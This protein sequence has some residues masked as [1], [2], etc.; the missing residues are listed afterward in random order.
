MNDP[1]IFQNFDDIPGNT[2]WNS[3][4]EEQEEEPEPIHYLDTI[5]WGN[6]I[7]WISY[8]NVVVEKALGGYS[9]LGETVGSAIEV[10]EIIDENESR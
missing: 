1:N 7:K 3:W 6:E 2:G 4:V 9:V 10:D 5:K 8:R